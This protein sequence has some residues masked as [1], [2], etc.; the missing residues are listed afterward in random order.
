M[1][2]LQKLN[3]ITNMFLGWASSEAIATRFLPL[4][5]GARGTEF[6]WKYIQMSFISNFNL[7]RRR[8]TNLII[9][10]TFMICSVI[11]IIIINDLFV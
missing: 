4:W 3:L 7:V 10:N 2:D 6:D 11:I 1:T 5:F 8:H 9:N